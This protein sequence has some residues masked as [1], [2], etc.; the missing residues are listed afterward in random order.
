MRLLNHILLSLR[1]GHGEASVARLLV[2]EGLLGRLLRQLS[3]VEGVESVGG[4][5]LGAGGDNLGSL[6]LPGGFG[7][8]LRARLRFLQGNLARVG[9]RLGLHV[10][11]L[12]G[13]GEV[14]RGLLRRRRR[15]GGFVGG[16]LRLRRPRLGL[17][18][19]TLQGLDAI[20][21]VGVRHARGLVQRGRRG[22]LRVLIERVVLE[23]LDAGGG[24]LAV[25]LIRLRGELVILARLHGELLQALSLGVRLG[26]DSVGRLEGSAGVAPGLR[27]LRGGGGGRAAVSLRLGEAR[28]EAGLAEGGAQDGG[29]AG[30]DHRE[31]AEAADERRARPADGARGGPGGDGLCARWRG[32]ARGEEV[33]GE[34]IGR[35]LATA[36]EKI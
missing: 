19:L 12:G 5:L 32:K 33:R 16:G 31:D 4:A 29:R 7:D 1:G 34:R 3:A 15:G 23:C 24:E 10:E 21:A 17:L 25:V 28:A 6:R 27:A 30:G 26:E 13:F 18:E 22:Q 36:W 2:H 35:L 14:V 8:S 11:F 9:V 20:G